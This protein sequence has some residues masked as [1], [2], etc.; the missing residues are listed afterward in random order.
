MR[1]DDPDGGARILAVEDDRALR[2][3]LELATCAAS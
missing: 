3:V 1:R 2:R